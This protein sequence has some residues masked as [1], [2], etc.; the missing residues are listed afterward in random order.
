MQQYLMPTTK[1]RLFL[2]P[3]LKSAQKYFLTDQFK[4]SLPQKLEKDVHEY[5]S[6][7][8]V[9]NTMYPTFGKHNI[10]DEE[11][12]NVKIFYRRDFVRCCEE[13]V[14]FLTMEITFRVPIHIGK[15]VKISCTLPTSSKPRCKSVYS[16]FQLLHFLKFNCRVRSMKQRCRK[17]SNA[18]V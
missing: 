10:K 15:L 13:K 9:C 3:I 5:S 7:F 17:C 12:R 14:M 4:A 18:F 1:N 8:R 11:V 2:D 6:A 16:G